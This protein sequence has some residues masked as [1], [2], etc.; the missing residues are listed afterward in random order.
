MLSW[1]GSVRE[2]AAKIKFLQVTEFSCEVI[3]RHVH[4]SLLLAWV[5]YLSF[6]FSLHPNFVILPFAGLFAFAVTV[7]V[8]TFKKYL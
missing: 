4:P 7:T 2:M 3:I 8:G 6:P 5:V 1:V